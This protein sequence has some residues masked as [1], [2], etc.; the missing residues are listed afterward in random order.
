MVIPVGDTCL[1]LPSVHREVAFPVLCC[2][3]RGMVEPLLCALIYSPPI[4]G[5]MEEQ[6]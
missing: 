4:A 3:S 1:Y 6:R 2:W 5:T